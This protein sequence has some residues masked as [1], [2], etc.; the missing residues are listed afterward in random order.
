LQ[1]WKLCEG[2]PA[3]NGYFQKVSINWYL[4]FIFG[5]MDKETSLF[6]LLSF[7]GVTFLGKV[8][9]DLNWQNVVTS[10]C[11]IIIALAAAYK[12]IKEGQKNSR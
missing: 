11:Q 4:F 5:Y 9:N 10:C 3:L 8:N 1:R 7:L 2:Y 12:L 6:T